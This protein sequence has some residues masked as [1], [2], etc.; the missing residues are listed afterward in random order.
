MPTVW[1]LKN[2]KPHQNGKNIA[3]EFIYATA[4]AYDIR[5]EN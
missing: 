5:F 1:N 3:D 4:L 2:L